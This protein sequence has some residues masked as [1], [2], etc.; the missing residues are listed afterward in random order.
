MRQRFPR[1]ASL[2]ETSKGWTLDQRARFGA[3]LDW[4]ASAAAPRASDETHFTSECRVEAVREECRLSEEMW[5]RLR[6]AWLGLALK[7]SWQQVISAA[8]NSFHQVIPDPDSPP[9]GAFQGP[10]I[11]IQ[12]RPIRLGRIYRPREAARRRQEQ[13][14]VP[15]SLGGTYGSEANEH[16][17]L[18]LSSPLIWA[19]WKGDDSSGSPFADMASPEIIVRRLGLS[20]HPQSFQSVRIIHYRLPLDRLLHIPI[21]PDAIAHGNDGPCWYPFFRPASRLVPHGVTRALAPCEDLGGL[22]E[23]IH[24]SLEDVPV[25]DLA[26]ESVLRPQR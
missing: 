25:S 20:W 12:I 19:T 4:L 9:A 24:R 8:Y 16:R 26:I 3:L 10:I 2:V 18:A 7:P 11:G 21:L 17:S 14:L 23:G 13:A 5:R 6:D 22:P 1:M 15:K